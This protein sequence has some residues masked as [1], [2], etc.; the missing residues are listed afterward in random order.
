M[1]IYIQK[2]F[3]GCS[4]I[5]TYKKYLQVARE[6][7]GNCG[8]LT[9]G[10]KWGSQCGKKKFFKRKGDDGDKKKLLGVK[11]WSV[12]EDNLHACSSTQVTLITML[13]HCTMG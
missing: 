13:H 12:G 9:A 10:A 11:K 7:T 6:A 2:I 5:F 1:N 4:R 8:H 3:T